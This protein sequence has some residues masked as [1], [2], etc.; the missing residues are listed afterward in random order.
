MDRALREADGPRR[1]ILEAAKLR[2]VIR[3]LDP[4]AAAPAVAPVVAPAARV[5]RPAPAADPA[6][7]HP[8]ASPPPVVRPVAA[9]PAEP[10]PQ[11]AGTER[12]VAAP[13]TRA[14]PVPAPAAPVPEPQP[15]AVPVAAPPQ[16][17]AAAAPV[18]LAPLKL[19]RTVEPDVPG[20]LLR[21]TNARLQAVVSFTV[22]TDG[23]V[24]DVVVRSSTSAELDAPVVE[25]VRQWRYEPTPVAREQTVELVI[26]P[27]V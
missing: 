20:R 4:P 12:P 3:V 10:A 26:R 14:E 19:L 6:A 11:T 7:T 27:P 18:V 5:A 24:S 8:V 13:P 17:V 22:G 9:A 21:R 15:V 25:A 16:A 1:R 2:T 23:T